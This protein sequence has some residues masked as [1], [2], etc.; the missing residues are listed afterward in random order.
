MALPSLKRKRSTSPN[1]G[2][3]SGSDDVSILA[4]NLFV[5]SHVS[6]GRDAVA[7]SSPYADCT[8]EELL[9]LFRQGTREAFGTLVRR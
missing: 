3:A 4:V 9:A 1:F 5:I 8:D 6:I 7:R 2:Y